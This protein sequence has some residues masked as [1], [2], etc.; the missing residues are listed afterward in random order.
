MKNTLFLFLFSLFFVAC[1][2]G[3]STSKNNS[4]VGENSSESDSNS[5]KSSSSSVVIPGLIGNLIDSR[6][7]QTYKTVQIGSQIWMAQ[8]LNYETASSYCYNDSASYCAKYGRLYTWAV[9][10]DSAGTWTT[11]GKGCGNDKTCSPTYP[12]R[13]VCPSG[14]HLPTQTEWNTLFTAVGGQS[15]ASTKLKSSSGWNSDG[16][17]TDS[18]GFS[19]LPA[20]GRDNGV[21]DY[22]GYGAYF[23]SSTE[24]DSDF[25]CDMN[26][27]F[28]F[29]DGYAYLNDLNKYNGF[30]VR[31]VKD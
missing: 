31:C 13:G 10:M 9:A 27:D 20:G 8:N 11:N 30:S 4:K 26:L 14:W 15:T 17:G 18:F 6:D 28:F 16:N 12:V 21:Y 19:A 1:G 3:S 29:D 25:A 7:G 5:T 23:W 22:E 2:D 24:N